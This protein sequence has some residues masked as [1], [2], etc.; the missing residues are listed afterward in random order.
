MATEKLKS[1]TRRLLPKG[2]FARSASLLAGGTAAGQLIIVAASPILTRLYS[3]E[4]FGALA[5]FTSLLGTLG[6]IASLR[7]QLAIPL[8]ESNKEAANVTVLSLV[9][10]L[11]MVLITALIAIPFRHSI[12]EALNTPL[13]AEYIWLVPLG[14]LLLGTYEV[15]NY[16]AIR[17]RAFGTIAQTKLTQSLGMVGVQIGGYALG[18]IALLAGRIFGQ[19]AGM[20]RLG[21]LIINSRDQFLAVRPSGIKASLKNYR[22]FPLISTWSGLSGAGGTHL[23]PI[24]IAIILGPVATGLYALTHR[25]LSLPVGVISKSIGDVFYSE[26]IEAKASGNL[27]ALVTDIYS[28][29]V[30]SSLPI[31]VV[32]IF[33]APDVFRILFGDNWA[34]SGELASWMTLWIF[35]QFVTT[36][37]GRV[38]LILDRHGY[39]LLFQL[40]LLLVTTL[41]IVIG[42]FW[43]ED[44]ITIM[45]M[46]AL[47]RSAVYCL[48]FWKILNL[49]GE[50][51]KKI[52]TPILAS[53]PYAIL[54]SLPAIYS[55]ALIG[56]NN[57]NSYLT[58]SLFLV[59]ALMATIPSFKLFIAKGTD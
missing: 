14:L 38:F 11:A 8:P 24:L 55:T 28:K 3:P 40:S 37:P 21:A 54:C 50:R 23:P 19:A 15:C 58:S 2:R 26:A 12:A 52:W 36:P 17:N 5:V 57:T 47:G 13:I 22:S 1:I 41:S 45:A 7:Y 33:S 31:A 30:R 48:R 20:Y 53:F 35:F 43:S 51:F 27:G 56:A 16:W 46:L 10:V 34:R 29:M 25:V 6:V 44:L 9:I 59:S 4:D 42:G 49:V 18:P 39:A 32:L